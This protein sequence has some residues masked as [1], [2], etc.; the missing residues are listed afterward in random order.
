[1][2]I[3]HTNPLLT[4][5]LLVISELMSDI[6]SFHH[7]IKVPKESNLGPQVLPSDAI[8]EPPRPKNVLL[9]RM[10]L[11]KHGVGVKKLSNIYRC[12]NYKLV[13][14]LDQT[15]LISISKSF[16]HTQATNSK[17]IQ[18]LLP[19]FKLLQALKLDARS[20]N[21]ISIQQLHLNLQH[22]SFLSVLQSKLHHTRGVSA[23]KLNELFR[24][25][26]RLSGLS[27]L[28]LDLNRGEL[29]EESGKTLGKSIRYL[30]GLSALKLKSVFL[31]DAAFKQLAVSLGRLPHL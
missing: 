9:K 12:R 1:M 10:I 17:R 16:R 13:C 23:E 26:R 22:L 20:E 24:Q 28:T 18:T 2:G 5:N 30:Q 19:R 7:S 25:F 4:F 29:R 31:S 14:E 21:N 8:T 6:Q 27:S 15:N 11:Q 3:N